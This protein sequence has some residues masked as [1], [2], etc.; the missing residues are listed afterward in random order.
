MPIYIRACIRIWC[1]K[2]SVYIVYISYTHLY[3]HMYTCTYI[4]THI[5]TCMYTYMVYRDQAYTS[6]VYHI[7]IYMP[8][9][10]HVHTYAPLYIRTHTYWWKHI[11]PLICPYVHMYIHM[12]PCIYEPTRIGGN[13]CTSLYIYICT[14][15]HPCTKKCN[16]KIQHVHKHKKNQGWHLIHVKKKSLYILDVLYCIFSISTICIV[17]LLYTQ[18]MLFKKHVKIIHEV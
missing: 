8:I 10:K 13:T 7:P 3:A 16:K 18:Y 6:Y 15:I 5:Y 12:H 9:C 4:C 2:T 17:V 11:H 14:H 1:I